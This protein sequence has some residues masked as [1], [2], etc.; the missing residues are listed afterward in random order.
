ML[1]T[2]LPYSPDLGIIYAVRIP[3]KLVSCA[4][5]NGALIWGLLTMG[6]QKL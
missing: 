3:I 5:L 2:F 4:L 1:K 6:F